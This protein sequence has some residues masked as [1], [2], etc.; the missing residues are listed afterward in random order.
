MDSTK[1]GFFSPYPEI[2]ALVKAQIPTY[3]QCELHEIKYPGGQ[4]FSEESQ[5]SRGNVDISFIKCI[6]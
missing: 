5:L 4:I 2:I 3:C 6:F 1:I